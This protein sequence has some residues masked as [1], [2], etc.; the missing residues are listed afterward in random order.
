MIVPTSAKVGYRRK[1]LKSRSSRSGI[2]FARLL[3]EHRRCLSRDRIREA[4]SSRDVNSAVRVAGWCIGAGRVRRRAR[5]QIAWR[6][7]ERPTFLSRRDLVEAEDQICYCFH[8]SKRKILNFIRL[9]KP[10]RASQIS[11]CGGAGTGCGWCVPYL[12]RYFDDAVAGCV[13]SSDEMTPEKYARLRGTYLAAGKG[14]PPPGATPP[15]SLDATTP[16]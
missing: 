11:E 10:R 8:I 9:S 12:K 6:C 14:T 1:L 16:E 13:T 2:F 7:V 15:P 5:G 4:V 3:L